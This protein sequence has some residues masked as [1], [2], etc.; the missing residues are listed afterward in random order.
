MSYEKPVT[1]TYVAHPVDANGMANYS[2]EDNAVW[3]TLYP[4]QLPIV[5]AF[6]CD[7]FLNG[8]KILNLSPD[9]VPQCPEVSAALQ[10]TT[11]WSLQPVPAI[12]PY[13]KF[14]QLLS[15]RKF[16]AATFIRRREELDYLQEPDIFHEVW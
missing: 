8:I 7:E 6:A 4:R 10:S 16:P 3:H 1:A 11:G 2:A 5:E 14:F 13:D 9:H 12:I 15:E